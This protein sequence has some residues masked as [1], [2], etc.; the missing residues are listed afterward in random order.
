MATTTPSVNFTGNA[1]KGAIGAAVGLGA[2]L[3]IGY[4]AKAKMSKKSKMWLTVATTL[5][6]A[7]VGYKHA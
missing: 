7:Y 4:L 1:Q 3:G 2:G 5:V 6:G